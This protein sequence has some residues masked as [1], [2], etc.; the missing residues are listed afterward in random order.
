V[1]SASRIFAESSKHLHDSD[2]PMVLYNVA[3]SYALQGLADE[4][5][6]CLEKVM[7][8]SSSGALHKIWAEQDSDLDSLRSN[9]RSQALLKSI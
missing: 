3:C 1:R 2:D 7:A 9:I 4:A 6:N 5:I 8:Q